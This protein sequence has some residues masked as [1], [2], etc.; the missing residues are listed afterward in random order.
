MAGNCVTEGLAR[1]AEA[2]AMRLG[3]VIEGRVTKTE[4]AGAMTIAYWTRESF[5]SEPVKHDGG[6]I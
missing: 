1:K 5:A 3:R 2:R 6:E 4:E